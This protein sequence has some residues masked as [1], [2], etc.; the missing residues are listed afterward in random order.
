MSGSGAPSAR[1]EWSIPIGNAET[2]RGGW[3]SSSLPPDVMTDLSLQL[4]SRAAR[5]RAL[6]ESREAQIARVAGGPATQVDRAVPQATGHWDQRAA[7]FDAFSRAHDLAADPLYRLLLR[8]ARGRRLLDVGAGAGRYAVPLA[9]VAAAVT[10]VEP[11]AGMRE[12]LAERL[13][14]AHCDNVRILAGSWPEAAAEAGRHDVALVSHAIYGTTDVL[15][16]LQ[17]LESSAPLRVVAIRVEPMGAAV[18]HLFCHVHGEP[19]IADPT[20]DTLLPVLLALGALPT[21]EYGSFGGGARFDSPDDAVAWAAEQLRL[22]AD[23]PRRG[24]L[25]EQ[26]RPLM[27]EIDGGWRW[28]KALHTAIVAWGDG[29]GRTDGTTS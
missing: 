13:A 2:G 9:S 6:V 29:E 21:V 28:R 5:W 20:L 19:P 23:D 14:E 24:P 1:T 3:P 10:A 11:S 22:A 4:A 15:G 17:A 8:R 7:A 27:V 18:R 26:V 16:F 12:R 25:W